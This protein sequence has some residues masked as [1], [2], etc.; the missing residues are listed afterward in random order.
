MEGELRP[1]ADVT[2]VGRHCALLPDGEEKKAALS[3][4]CQYFH[5]YLMKYLVMICRGHVP[6][7]R[8]GFGYVHVNKDVVPFIKFFL[9]KGT[10][11]NRQTLLVAVRHFHLAFKGMETEEVYDVLMEQLIRAVHKYDPNYTEKV[12]EVAEAID[13]EFLSKQKQFSVAD[14]SRFLEFDGNRYIRMLCRR[15]FLTERRKNGPEK[16][17]CTDRRQ[18]SKDL[19]VVHCGQE[20]LRTALST[21]LPLCEMKL[22]SRAA[23]PS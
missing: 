14:V 7:K 11:V 4:L 9:P 3:E 6:I 20:P 23:E 18:R 21:N 12:R 15:G 1:L 8:H 17:C 22:R 16:G 13:N 19:G 2:E 10:P 5:P